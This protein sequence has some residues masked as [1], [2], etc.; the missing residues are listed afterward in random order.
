MQFTLDNKAHKVIEVRM[1]T[2]STYV[3]RLTKNDFQFEAGQYLVMGTKNDHRKRE[4][5]I[6]SSPADSFLEVLIRE[7]EEGDVSKKL[8]RLKPG[9]Y[10]D[11]EGPYGR[12]NLSEASKSNEQKVLFIATG[13]GL[14]PCHSIVKTYPTLDYKVVHGVRYGHEAYEKDHYLQNRYLLCASRD[15]N[16]DFKGRVTDYLAQH[17]VDANTECYLCGNSNM[18]YEV[19]DLLREQGVN[20]KQIHTEVYF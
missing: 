8:K 17:P 15:E 5:S 11:V 3:L 18:I 10:V 19:F 9:D 13:T 20:R 4:Y 7:V 6:Y 1:L 16:G 2:E 12:F 14:S